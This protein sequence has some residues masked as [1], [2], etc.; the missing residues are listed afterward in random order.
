MCAIYPSCHHWNFVYSSRI[1]FFDKE[2]C[3]NGK[4]A[5][6]TTSSCV[7]LKCQKCLMNGHIENPMKYGRTRMTNKCALLF[8]IKKDSKSARKTLWYVS[9]EIIILS[10][11]HLH[12]KYSKHDSQYLKVGSFD[13]HTT[14][15]QTNFTQICHHTVQIK[16]H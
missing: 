12:Y 15:R 6:Q 4:W 11:P 5:C 7:M 3:A 10:G 8:F 14:Q 2:N 13:L 16:C 1:D 9:N